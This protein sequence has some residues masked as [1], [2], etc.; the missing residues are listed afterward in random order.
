M[1]KMILSQFDHLRKK[2]TSMS[3]RNISWSSQRNSL[4]AKYSVS[5]INWGVEFVCDQRRATLNGCYDNGIF[6]FLLHTQECHPASCENILER[7]SLA[8]ASRRTRECFELWAGTSWTSSMASMPSWNTF[9]PPPGAVPHQRAPPSSART[10][11]R[12]RR[13]WESWTRGRSQSNKREGARFCFS[14][15][16]T[17]RLLSD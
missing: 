8:F 2:Q 3:F 14:T 13:G 4:S 11:R 6:R 17:L 10:S 15:V 5:P 1:L 9:A 16:S 12:R 7:S